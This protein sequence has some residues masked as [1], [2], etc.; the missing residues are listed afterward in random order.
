MNRFIKKLQTVEIQNLME[1]F[2]TYCN[3]RY[4]EYFYIN[5]I[6]YK[7]FGDNTMQRENVNTLKTCS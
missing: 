4:R 2:K 1:K 7:T 6:I 5:L 3:C